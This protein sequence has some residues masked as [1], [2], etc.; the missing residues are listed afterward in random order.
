MLKTLL[1]ECTRSFNLAISGSW[2]PRTLKSDFFQN[3]EKNH[4]GP[5]LIPQPVAHSHYT[6]I[7]SFIC[8]KMELW[9]SMSRTTLAKPHK[10]IWKTRVCN[11][12]TRKSIWKTQVCNCKMNGKWLVLLSQDLC[13]LA[14]LNPDVG[15]CFHIFIK[16]TN[17][18]EN[19]EPAQTRWAES[20]QFVH[21][22]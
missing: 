17:Y 3:L 10:S 8:S 21:S 11:C 19:G 15:K 18:L 16:H 9:S 12:K 5:P 6:Q 20:G 7:P 22:C 2:G 13:L 14:K 1:P 4:R